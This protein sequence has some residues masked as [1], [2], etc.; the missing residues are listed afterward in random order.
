MGWL[1]CDM[2]IERVLVRAVLVV[3]ALAVASCGGSEDVADESQETDE[4][5]DPREGHFAE[6]ETSAVNAA[7]KAYNETIARLE[8]Q[9]LQDRCA[10]Q[11]PAS[12]ACYVEQVR[13]HAASVGGV[14]DTLADL[15]GSYV[16]ACE[17]ELDQATAF[18]DELRAAY[19]AVEQA[20]AEHPAGGPPVDAAYVHAFS[21]DAEEDD[22]FSR[23]LEELTAAC[24]IEADRSEE[25][26]EAGEREAGVR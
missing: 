6:G 20:W 12:N 10:A 24:M 3:T 15:D 4:A 5:E 13:Q 23:T 21:F 7:L 11:L 9:A 8:D 25:D 14:R 26:V 2:R 19:L 22:R 16:P 1:R 18:M 17:A